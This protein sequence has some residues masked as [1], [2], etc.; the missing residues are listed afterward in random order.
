VLHSVCFVSQHSASSL[1]HVT[2]VGDVG[3]GSPMPVSVLAHVASLADVVNT[4]L[5]LPDVVHKADP[6]AANGET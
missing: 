2:D 4:S 3:D 1:L 5:V 6:S